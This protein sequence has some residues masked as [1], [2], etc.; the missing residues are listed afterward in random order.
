MSGQGEALTID[1]MKFYTS[2]YNILL[3][4]NAAGSL[5]NIQLLADCI[6]MMFLKRRKQIPTARLL[7]FIKRL[8]IV[9]L[10]L[11]PAGTAVILNILRKLIN[12]KLN[13]KLNFEFKI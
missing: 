12:V 4:L 9:S 8:S 13:K 6:D 2:L 1:P 5:D 10:Q 7:A 11:E 3:N